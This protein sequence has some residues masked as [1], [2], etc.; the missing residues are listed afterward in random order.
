VALPPGYLKSEVETLKA[1]NAT[2]RELLR[3]LEDQ[4]KALLEQ[5]DRLQR[6]LD[7]V[8]TAVAPPGVQPRVADVPVPAAPEANAPGPAAN[9]GSTSA[10]QASVEQPGKEDRYQDGMV[11]WQNSEDAKVPFLLRFNNNTQIRYLNTTD[12]PDTF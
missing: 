3:R 4:Q 5:V 9:A 7:G 2:V 10:R 11:I 6:R 1:E 8:T 12:S